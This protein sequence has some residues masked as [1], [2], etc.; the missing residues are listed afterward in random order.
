LTIPTCLFCHLKLDETTKPEHILLNA[1]GGRMTT[2]IAVC[3]ICN[4]RFGGTIDNELASSVM[5]IRNWFKLKSGSGDQAPTLKGVQ[6][7]AQRINIK[8]D[9]RLEFV[10]KPFAVEDLGDGRWNLQI[11]LDAANFEDEL[12]RLIPH[13]AAKL[14]VTEDQLREQLL[15][16]HP[17][18]ISQRPATSGHEL[19]LGGPDALRSVIKASLVLWS[20]LVGN[21]EL[22]RVPYKAARRF[23]IEGDERFAL[24]RSRLDS[25]PFDDIEKMKAE[26]GPLFNLIYVRS[27]DVGR[28]IGHFTL[29]NAVA[30][31][32]TL[33]ESGGPP[34]TK[35]A[36]ISNPEE[37]SRWSDRAAE[38]FDIPFAWL[39]DP[40]Y[41][42]AQANARIRDIVKYYYASNRETPV[43]L[44][45]EDCC[46]TLGITPD[47]QLPAEKAAE[48][49]M[50]VSY[51]LGH[52]MLG[53]PYIEEITRERFAE[54]L[55]VPS[56]TR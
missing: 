48:L 12:K 19:A 30:W 53:V 37:S 50:L 46:K 28:V 54:I 45:M 43:H 17:S 22:K 36:L 5:P 23:V 25:R 10:D 52:Y 39:A 14:K 41:S 13:I 26:F 47:E 1:L 21:H 31:H 3:S 9:G 34:N 38:K 15:G 55:A 51:R 29:Y 33:A 20:T 35:I 44:I 24:D 27:D 56:R 8:G 49:E 16:A 7:G 32:F 2:N 6:A 40:N 11:S 42:L 4:N 18:L